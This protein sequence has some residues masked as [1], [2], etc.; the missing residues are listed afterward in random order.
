EEAPPGEARLAKMPPS[1][2]ISAAAIKPSRVETYPTHPELA[3]HLVGH[4]VDSGFDVAQSE[5]L[6]ERPGG[7]AHGMPH[8]FGFVYQRIM[9]G[10]VVPHVP[11]MLNTFYPPN[12]PRAGRCVDLGIR[13]AAAVAAWPAD[14]RVAIIASGG[15]THFV[16]DE[17][18]DRIVLDALQ[19]NDLDR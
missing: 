18:F 3:R 10:L 6:P 2:A 15:L 19:A 4:L 7:G 1:I 12:Q 16:I 11:I 17:D 8:A 9:R 14:L 5:R 13:L